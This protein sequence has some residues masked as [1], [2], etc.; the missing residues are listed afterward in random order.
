[1]LECLDGDLRDLL[2]R[3]PPGYACT[4]IGRRAT[5]S[6][7][8]QILRA[9]HAA[10]ARCVM[11][12]DLKP[13]NVLVDRARG[14]VKVADF[15][16]ARGFLPPHKPY[17]DRVVTLWYRAPELLLG[18]RS[19]GPAVDVWSVGCIVAEMLSRE[20]LFRAESEVGMLHQIFQALGTPADDEG[21]AEGGG[22]GAGA[23]GA[24]PESRQPAPSAAAAAAGPRP[25]SAAPAP[26]VAPPPL[27]AA[28][29]AFGSRW[30]GVREL[31]HW[32]PD[33]PQWRPRDLADLLPALA[34]DAAGLDLVG[35]LLCLDPS[36]RLTAGQALAHGWFDELRGLEGEEEEEEGGPEQRR[37]DD[38]A[39]AAA[40]EAQR[41][42]LQQQQQQQQQQQHFQQLQQAQQQHTHPHQHHL[43]QY[44]HLQQHHQQQ[45][46]QLQQQ[47]QAQ[48]QQ[49]QPQQP[50]WA[51][52]FPAGGGGG[53]G[54]GGAGIEPPATAVAWQMAPGPSPPPPQG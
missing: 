52:A 48:Q 40:E 51:S 3:H 34:G 24:G 13:Q 1:V 6:H 21:Q 53:G 33:F 35:R 7:A 12:R 43:H 18:A 23:G 47:Q 37:R 9:V 46:Q 19:Y 54:G 20:P 15:G 32:R 4:P 29:A 36:R 30:R 49:Q 42:H 38:A 28:A 17:T 22:G 50:H 2:D 27:P 39:A 25:A 44:Q 41:R 16:L 11:H 26:P 5:K 10:H 8:R 31:A 14:V 45:Q